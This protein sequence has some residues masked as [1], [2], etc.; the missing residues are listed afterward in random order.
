MGEKSRSGSD[1]AAGRNELVA[2]HAGGMEAEPRSALAGLVRVRDVVADAISP[3]HIA[4]DGKVW[5]LKYGWTIDSI[6]PN[7]VYTGEYYDYFLPLAHAYDNPRILLVGLGG[8]TIPFQLSKLMK[9]FELD[10][11][12]VSGKAARLAKV[13]A[14]DVP[15]NV[16]VGEGAEYVGST[17]KIY[18]VLMLDAY[19]G[20]RMPGQFFGSRF[21][22]DASRILANDGALA[23]HYGPTLLNR[24]RLKGYVER[25]KEHF[26]VFRADTGWDDSILVCMK[27]RGKEEME[28]RI[29]KRM[30]MKSTRACDDYF[31][32]AAYARMSE[33]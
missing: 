12:E 25:L 4:S 21:I 13:L 24:L 29:E 22:D 33:L 32:R 27:D 15:M 26:R 2:E 9:G 8:G 5:M 17:G 11:V 6:I 18:D 1:G 23:I 10:A 30:P 14:P 3:F 31:P 16:I 20:R 7:G 19:V 28:E